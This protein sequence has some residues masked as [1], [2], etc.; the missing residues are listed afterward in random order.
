MGG[1]ASLAQIPHE[2]IESEVPR[3]LGVIERS[4]IEQLTLSNEVLGHL[5][6]QSYSKPNLAS[7]Q[8]RAKSSRKKFVKPHQLPIHVKQLLNKIGVECPPNYSEEVI[9]EDDE[10]DDGNVRARTTSTKQLVTHIFQC[11]DA[12][13]HMVKVDPA[14]QHEMGF[15]EAYSELASESPSVVD[16]NKESVGRLLHEMITIYTLCGDTMRV[17]LQSSPDAAS[18]EDSYGRLPLHVGKY[19]VVSY[20]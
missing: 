13:Q 9:D 1:S 14:Q 7:P 6:R 3:S 11:L 18:V 2:M 15:D 20:E 12:L 10:K 19:Q 17:L 8:Q 4:Q 5:R 16:A